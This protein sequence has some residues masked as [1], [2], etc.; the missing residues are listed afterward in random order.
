MMAEKKAPFVAPQRKVGSV[1]GTFS[2]KDGIESRSRSAD[3]REEMIT[4]TDDGG[5]FTQPHG[6]TLASVLENTIWLSSLGHGRHQGGMIRHL[7]HTSGTERGS[8]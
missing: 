1:M 2:G 4:R 7:G 5:K 3:K 8:I 6:W